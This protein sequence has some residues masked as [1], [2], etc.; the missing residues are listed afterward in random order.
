MRTYNARSVSWKLQA[1]ENF[2]KDEKAGELPVHHLDEWLV[3][4][5][6]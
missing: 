3:Q 5:M 2:Q 1:E 4:N 6:E